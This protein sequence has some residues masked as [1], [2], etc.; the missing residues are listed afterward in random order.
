MG[1]I[2]KSLFFMLPEKS[3]LVAMSAEMD[4]SSRSGPSG[5]LRE[6]PNPGKA[7]DGLLGMHQGPCLDTTL[8]LKADIGKAIFQIEKWGSKRV[9]NRGKD[10]RAGFS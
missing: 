1:P 7:Y 10:F 3:P 2:P 5:Q 6:L 4:D 9:P 8:T